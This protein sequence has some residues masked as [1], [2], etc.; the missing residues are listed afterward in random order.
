MHFF[1]T[2][3]TYYVIAPNFGTVWI[4][5][6][7]QHGNSHTLTRQSLMP[8]RSYVQMVFAIAIHSVLIKLTS[9][10]LETIKI[11]RIFL[12]NTTGADI[13]GH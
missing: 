12:P 10:H 13:A 1:G 11:M 4:D 8:S 2:N 7:V 5:I 6:V 9:I 3:N